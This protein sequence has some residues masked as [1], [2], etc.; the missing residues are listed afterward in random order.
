MKIVLEKR[1]DPL[2]GYDYSW[3]IEEPDTREDIEKVIEAF[4]SLC[5][6]VWISFDGYHDMDT[7]ENHVSFRS[8]EEFRNGRDEVD[9]IGAD[10]CSVHGDI[11]GERGVVL[12]F[13]FYGD[14]NNGVV[15]YVIA[16]S[17]EVQKKCDRALRETLMK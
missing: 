4:V 7:H 15:F 5:D 6:D 1:K 16:N 10:A 2:G 3:Y 13:S 12:R 11:D 14:S 17:E 8:M 9:R